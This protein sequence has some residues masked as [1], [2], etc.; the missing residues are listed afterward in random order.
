M[1]NNN[2]AKALLLQ[3]VDPGVGRWWKVELERKV[4]GKPI[5]VSL[6]ENS[7]VV[8]GRKSFATELGYDRTIA[9]PDSVRN[10]AERIVTEVG[11]YADVVG[12]YCTEG[13]N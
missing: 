4:K 7:E 10:A 11:D 9:D 3:K 5:R 6:M 13:M 12:E 1:A 8:K 2:N